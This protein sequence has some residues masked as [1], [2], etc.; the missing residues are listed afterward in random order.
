MAGKSAGSRKTT[1]GKTSSSRTASRK[2]TKKNGYAQ[3]SE[4]E[5]FL[6]SEVFVIASFAVA[7]LLFLSN[8][9]LCGFIGDYLRSF[10]LGIFGTI[11]FIAPVLLFVG[12]C[13][14]LS[15]KG[16]PIA[17]FKLASVI[18]GILVMC[19]LMEMFFTGGYQQGRTLA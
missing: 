12:T 8:F 14:A 9:K 5:E 4:Q 17:V 1:Q 19:A 3:P 15:N 6:R 18:V 10:Q 11:G 13:F 7:V 2:T 16:N